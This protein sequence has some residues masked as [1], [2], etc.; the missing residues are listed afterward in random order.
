MCIMRH[1]WVW[2]QTVE[3]KECNGRLILVNF[4]HN[5]MV[6]FRELCSQSLIKVDQRQSN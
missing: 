1:P 4:G 3:F 6:G 5:Q 2:N